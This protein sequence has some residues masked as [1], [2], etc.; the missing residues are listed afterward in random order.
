MP[1]IQSVECNALTGSL[2]LE[3][4]ANEHTTESLIDELGVSLERKSGP[5]R[6]TAQRTRSGRPILGDPV[7]MIGSLGLTVGA[8]AIGLPHLHLWSGVV[9]V[10]GATEHAYRH[11]EALQDRLR[12]GRDSPEGR[13]Q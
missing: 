1:G 13:G 6:A 5:H 11:R 8:L 3:Y 7:V 9:F 4:E 2:L 10:A 12:G